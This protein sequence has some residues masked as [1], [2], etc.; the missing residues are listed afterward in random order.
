R[1]RPV[2]VTEFSVLAASRYPRVEAT[3]G[4]TLAYSVEH[5]HSGYNA[6]RYHL[7]AYRTPERPTLFGSVIGP[8]IRQRPVI[9]AV[10]DGR[11]DLAA[12][13]GDGLDLLRPHAPEIG[14]RVRVIDTTLPAP[15]APLVA[16]P[17]TPPEACEKLTAALLQA[18]TMPELKATLDD[19]LISRF[20]RVEPADF[21]VFLERERA[22]EAAGYPRLA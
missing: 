2:Y 16:S 15:S 5:S 1:A 7:L 3:L 18:H 19:V 8:F 13:D 11:A 14:N 6:P 4:R 17:G 12:V 9:E 10:I 22:A 21:E 20:V